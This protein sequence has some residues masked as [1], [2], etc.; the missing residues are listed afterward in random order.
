MGSNMDVCQEEVSSISILQQL[1]EQIK[2]QQAQIQ[3]QQDC[4]IQ[5]QNYQQHQ[6]VTNY[7]SLKNQTLEPTKEK[8][9]LLEKFNGDR[10]MWDEWHL[11]A[12]H[13]LN[14][15]GEFI[16]DGYDQFTYLYSRLSGDAARM[17][18]TVARGLSED[19]AGDGEQFLEYLDT[20]FGDPNK[21]AR[22][23]QDLLNIKQ[24]PKETFAAFLP[25]FETLLATA[26]LSSY[27]E[28]H[29]ISLL[30]NAISKELKDRLV[31]SDPFRTWSMFV[32]K[33]HTI[34][35]DLNALNQQSFGVVPLVQQ[36][37]KNNDQM[38]WEPIQTASLKTDSKKRATWVS[39][40]VLSF[41]RSKNLCMRCGNKGHISPSCSF[42]PALKPKFQVNNINTSTEEEEE[43]R[44][45]AQPDSL[46]GEGKEQLLQ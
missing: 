32:S 34:S 23:Q 4:I 30:K 21:K 19:R 39:K 1:Q 29:K 10:Q 6:D 37:R 46:N 3:K 24:K 45:L 22:A 16:G 20:V 7:A 14:K 33:I 17:V 8:L 36:Q 5:L 15:D 9:P 12:I 2:L 40:E 27:S 18:S 42:L 31:G 13:K 41:R 26:G 43:I 25:R 38:E 11:S 35:S 28:V 44:K